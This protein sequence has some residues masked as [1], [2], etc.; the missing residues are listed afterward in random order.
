MRRIDNDRLEAL[1]AEY[2]ITKVCTDELGELILRLVAGLV[3]MPS[4]R[5]LAKDVQD[6]LLGDGV[7]KALEVLEKYNPKTGSKAHSYLTACV[8]N[9]MRNYLAANKQ[10]YSKL[11]CVHDNLVA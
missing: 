6:E 10:Y 11:V 7:I 9:K 3:A 2:K 1:I 4:F 5:F 8:F